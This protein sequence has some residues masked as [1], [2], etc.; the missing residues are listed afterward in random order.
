MH[1]MSATRSVPVGR[2][3]LAAAVFAAAVLLAAVAGGLGASGSGSTYQSLELPVWAPP[4]WLFGPVWTALYVLIAFAG[5]LV[6][7]SSGLSGA[8][9]F[10]VLYVLQ[11]VLNAAWTPLFFGAGLY[12]AALID[13][14]LLTVIVAATAVLALRHSRLA[15]VLLVPYSLWVGFATALNLAVWAAN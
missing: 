12:G 10:Y 8:T 4:S 9:A 11:L 2:A 7:R 6:W 14:A 15:A 13:L 3:L 5:W 1:A